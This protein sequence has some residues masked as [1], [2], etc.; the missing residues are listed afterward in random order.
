VPVNRPSSAGF[1]QQAAAQATLRRTFNLTD[2]A[3]VFTDELPVV[4]LPRLVFWLFQVTL[5]VASRVE[6]QFSVRM[7]TGATPVPEWLPLV[8]PYLL[9][10]GTPVRV[11]FAMPCRAIRVALT[12]SPGVNTQIELVIAGAASS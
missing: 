6:P 11:D 12:R 2:D 1:T 8:P 10:P 5:G 4:G 9:T 3:T 7:T